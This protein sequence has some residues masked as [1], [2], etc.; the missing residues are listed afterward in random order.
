MLLFLICFINIGK[1]PKF[2]ESQFINTSNKK[3][4]VTSMVIKVYRAYESTWETC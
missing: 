1:S 3:L 4:C 2:S